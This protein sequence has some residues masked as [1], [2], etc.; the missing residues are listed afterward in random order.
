MTF[1][2]DRRIRINGF[3]IQFESIANLTIN[4]RE[5]QEEFMMARLNPMDFCLN[6]GEYIGERGFYSKKCHD[7]Y[8]DKVT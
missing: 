7:E 5:K 4:K 1:D 6:C 3:E 8:Y 2:W